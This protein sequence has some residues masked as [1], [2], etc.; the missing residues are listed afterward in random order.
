MKANKYQTL[1]QHLKA[2]AIIARNI[3]REIT[4]N[5]TIIEQSYLAGLL[6]DTGK[7]CPNWQ[8]KIRKR[9]R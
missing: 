6:H 5:K 1:E 7:A 8:K 4:D 9:K 2:V 3:A